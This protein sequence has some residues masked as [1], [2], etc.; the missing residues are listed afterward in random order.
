MKRNKRLT[1][2]D[3][4]K[5]EANKVIYYTDKTKQFIIALLQF[6]YMMYVPQIEPPSQDNHQIVHTHPS[7]CLYETIT[8]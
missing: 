5:A 7:E 8:H 1:T 4:G 3:S 6:T 2:E